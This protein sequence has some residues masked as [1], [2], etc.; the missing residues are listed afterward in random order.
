[1]LHVDT[2]PMLRILAS[3]FFLQHLPQGFCFFFLIL[4]GVHIYS[5][6]TVFL[7]ISLPDIPEN[8]LFELRSNGCIIVNQ[9]KGGRNQ[10]RALWADMRTLGWNE[11]NSEGIKQRCMQLICRKRRGE[12]ERGTWK[13]R[14]KHMARSLL[15]T[16]GWCF[17]LY[18]H[19]KVREGN[20]RAS[21][22]VLFYLDF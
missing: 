10:K 19:W 5:A 9:P 7:E 6:C 1:M 15:A 3:P 8:V 21:L 17:L 20:F 14:Q 18:K 12:G 16:S 13:S 11:Q 4:I 22:C 2:Y